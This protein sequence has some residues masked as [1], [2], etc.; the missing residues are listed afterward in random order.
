MGIAAYLLLPISWEGVSHPHVCGANSEKQG[1]SIQY[2][3]VEKMG[4]TWRVWLIQ[5]NRMRRWTV[6]Q[7]KR[8]SSC[9]SRKSGPCIH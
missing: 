8:M 7:S 3:L 1:E 5:P 4:L 6:R 2:S 9:S